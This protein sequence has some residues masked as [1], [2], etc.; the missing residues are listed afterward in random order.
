MPENRR[1]ISFALSHSSDA[2]EMHPLS[3][4]CAPE[5]FRFTAIPTFRAFVR[6]PNKGAPPKTLVKIK[7][8]EP[9][10]SLVAQME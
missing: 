10:I 6:S 2:R 4:H 8:N 5:Y 7:A 9:K 3:T 1:V